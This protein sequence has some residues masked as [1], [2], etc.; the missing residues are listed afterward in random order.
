MRESLRWNKLKFIAQRYIRSR[1]ELTRFHLV[2]SNYTLFI[3]IGREVLFWSRLIAIITL[4]V[5]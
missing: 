4:D 3:V 5:N 2:K 1:L